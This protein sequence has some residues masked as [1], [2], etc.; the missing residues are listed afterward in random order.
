MAKERI[1]TINEVRD[2]WDTRPCNIR[3]SNK[4]KGS[5]EFFDEVEKKRYKA[6][7][8]IVKFV[9]FDSFEGKSVLK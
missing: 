1:P 7:P 9:D 2:F 6:E 8:H 5:R 3:H 4:D